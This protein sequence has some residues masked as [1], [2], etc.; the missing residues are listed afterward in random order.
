MHTIFYLVCWGKRR[1]MTRNLSQPMSHLSYR[2]VIGLNSE[3]KSF[4][5]LRPAELPDFTPVTVL[6]ALIPLL[7]RVSSPK[8]KLRYSNHRSLMPGRLLQTS[9]LYLGLYS[10]FLYSP[11]QNSLFSPPKAVSSFV[12]NSNR[13]FSVKIKLVLQTICFHLKVSR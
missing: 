3:D 9:L 12:S 10:I 8:E 13:F 11:K 6:H 4:T 2:R 5:P 7:C 1:L